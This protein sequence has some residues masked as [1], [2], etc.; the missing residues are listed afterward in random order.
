MNELHEYSDALFEGIGRGLIASVRYFADL[1]VGCLILL[2][3]LISVAEGRLV[4][5]EEV[6]GLQLRGEWTDRTCVR[7]LF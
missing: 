2:L 3:S 4:K 5:S 6:P 7:S 1:L